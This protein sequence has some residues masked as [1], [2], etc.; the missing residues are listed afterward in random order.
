MR[1]LLVFVMALAACGPGG[2]EAADTTDTRDTGGP[3][4]VEGVVTLPAG[5]GLAVTELRI[6]TP[7]GMRPI[8]VDGSFRFALEGSGPQWLDVLGPDGR[9]VLMGLARDG[10]AE[11]SANTT[12]RALLTLAL[13]GHLLPVEHAATLDGLLAEHPASESLA[14]TVTAALGAKTYVVADGDEGLT[15]ALQEARDAALPDVP[16]V[17]RA[18][19]TGSN[20]EPTDVVLEPG[21]GVLQSGVAVLQNPA[22]RGLV[23]QNHYR[24]P[25]ELLA[26]EVGV[27]VDGVKVETNPPKRVGDAVRAPATGK[28]ELFTALGDVLSGGAPWTPVL[29][30]PF[31]LPLSES[32]RT[33]YEL[34][35]LGPT[36]DMVTRPPLFD[37]LRFVGEREGWTSRIEAL[38]LDMFLSELMLPLLESF[39]FGKTA[40][41]AQGKRAA[42]IARFKQMNDAG[43]A[44]LGVF[45][46]TKSGLAQA[47]HLVL[48]DLAAG[49][50]GYRLDFLEA[51]GEALSESEKSRVDF[52]ALD[53]RLAA[54]ASAATVLAAVQIALTSGDVAAMLKDLEAARTAEAWQATASP[55][56][57]VL[58]PD[59]VVVHEDHP[60]QVFKATVRGDAANQRWTY[61]WSTTGGHGYLSDYLTDG[62]TLV[63]DKNEVF[64]QVTN[65]L[66]ITDDLRDTVV[67]ELFSEGDGPPGGVAV[68]RAVATI[69]GRHWD[70]DSRLV[71]EQCSGV[72]G[73]WIQD[74]GLP[75]EKLHEGNCAFMSLRFPKV[76]SATSYTISMEGDPDGGNLG[77]GDLD[78][79]NNGELARG[80]GVWSKTFRVPADTFPYPGD[81]WCKPGRG[82]PA[83]FVLSEV[84]G[85]MWLTIWFATEHPQFLFPVDN[86][87]P[88][89][90]N[91]SQRI[92]LWYEWMDGAE[93][94]VKRSP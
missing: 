29:S 72:P 23:V 79:N 52:E 83:G 73:M 9:L 63:T 7:G 14:E 77:A 31:G 54:R 15:R 39:L 11:V 16:R 25:V 47:M 40:V 42:F 22:G 94:E 27:E 58:R 68:G 41:L 59:A 88:D 19:L 85:E 67:V 1:F 71:V 91:L 61:R 24:R 43:L 81:C 80:F 20:V 65:P 35:V 2:G 5:F 66:A 86:Y 32:R 60:Q 89:L 93:I 84:G 21:G 51:I 18:A 6:A 33:H 44:S 26:Y 36:F 30:E 13:G 87:N 53:A 37:D 10:R 49:G 3:V 90:L 55:P 75:S 4:A 34:V 92:M 17:I 46:R 82:G 8:A 45:L 57:V 64:Y 56:F 69:E 28:L 74:Q 78:W 38:G 48:D 76:A 12:A 62:A 70:L 50:G